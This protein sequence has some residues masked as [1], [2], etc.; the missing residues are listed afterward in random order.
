MPAHV[1]GMIVV[2]AEGVQPK[3]R[4]QCAPGDTLIVEVIGTHRCKPATYA[5]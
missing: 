1:V 5:S 3:A 2:D 4:L